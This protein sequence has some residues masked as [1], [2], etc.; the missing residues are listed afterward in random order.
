MIREEDFSISL[1]V[2]GTKLP[3]NGYVKR[4]FAS[5]ILSLVTTLHGGENPD[6]IEIKLEKL[7]K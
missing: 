1:K 3:V 2:S 7:D 4:V 6:L 5:V